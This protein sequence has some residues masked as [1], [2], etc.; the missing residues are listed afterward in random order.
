[1]AYG[2]IAAGCCLLFMAT[3][4]IVARMTPW[5][6]WPIIRLVILFLLAIG[7]GLVSLLWF[8]DLTPEEE[9]DDEARVD[10]CLQYLAT[11][12][13]LITIFVVYTVVLILTHIGDAIAKDP[14]KSLKNSVS[15]PNEK[16]SHDPASVPLT[17]SIDWSKQQEAESPE[18]PNNSH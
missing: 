3:L 4:S 7:T 10:R 12:W 9:A 8:D 17:S 6:P 13:V 15:S 16:S 5:K 2:Y 11:P 1:F 18:G 14:S